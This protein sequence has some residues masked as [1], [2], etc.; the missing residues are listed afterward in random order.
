MLCPVCHVHARRGFPFCLRCG[1]A[2]KRGGGTA[3]PPAELH[4][5]GDQAFALGR[6]CTSI[7]RS[8]DNDLVIDDPYVSRYHARI[9]RDPDGYRL[10]DLDSLNGTF[11]NGQRMAA[12]GT[13]QVNDRDTVGVGPTICLSFE[14]PRTAAVGARTVVGSASTTILTTSGFAAVQGQAEVHDPMAFRPRRR[15]QWALKQVASSADAPRYVLRNE[16][17]GAHVQLTDR[18][19]FLWGLMDGT[20]TV[21]DLLLA[22]AER[23]GQLAL[24]RIQQLIGQLRRADLVS[25][26]H[27]LGA[28]TANRRSPAQTLIAM[29]TRAELAV[30]GLD[31]ILDSV[32]RTVGWRFFTRSG[33]LL[34]WAVVI[35]G[36]ASL[37]TAI[38]RNQ[39]LDVG[40]AGVIGGVL[41]VLGYVVGIVLHELG[42]AIATKSYGRRVRRGG[43]M[44][45]LGMPYAFVDTTEMW[46]ESRWPRILV[47]LAGP[48]VTAAFAGLACAGAAFIPGNVAPGILFQIALGLYTNTLFN[49]NPLITLDGYYALADLVGMPDLRQQVIRYFARGTWAR[50]IVG[51]RF[52]IRQ[53]GMTIYGACALVGT[54]GFLLLGVY[55][56]RARLSGWVH[57]AL[58]SPYDQLVIY[59]LILL[60]FFPIWYP[61]TMS[62]LRQARRLRGPSPAPAQALA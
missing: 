52:G 43:F 21:E 46:F 9:W 40:G 57:G 20:N 48:V 15:G 16:T 26:P 7:G 5:G 28:S 34:L 10:E 54:V 8:P 17:T 36:L 18:D 4:V 35:A 51:R 29:L 59:A 1:Q 13:L 12:G 49:F 61:L 45:M 2:I 31:G 58:R 42:H 6:P 33:L 55:M 44:L 60:L 56:W 23:F 37:P 50:D 24:P 62:L 19:I 3:V 25:S 53:L 30:S 47:S 38:G 32:Y 39:L 22:C 14:Q 41:V 11:V 27:R